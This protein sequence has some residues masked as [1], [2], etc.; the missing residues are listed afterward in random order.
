MIMIYLS[1]PF[2][3]FRLGILFLKN[4]LKKNYIPRGLFDVI[5]IVNRYRG[6]IIARS[7]FG[8]ILFD[9][10]IS[11]KI[12]DCIIKYEE[13]KKYYFNGTIITIYIPENQFGIETKL[14]KPQYLF[15]ATKKKSF[16]LNILSIQKEAIKTISQRHGKNGII[17]NLYNYTLDKISHF[18]DSLQNQKCCVFIDF[19]GFFS[20]S[21]LTKKLLFFLSSDYRINEQTNAVI[22]NLQDRDLILQVQLEILQSPEEDLNYIYHPIPCII[23]NSN[24]LEVLWLG[25]KNEISSENF[26]LVLK[27][28]IHDRS[29]S[30]FENINEISNTG[31]FHV[32]EYGNLIT[33]IGTLRD[34]SLEQ[35]LNKATLNENNRIYLC[36]GNYYQFEYLAIL[37]HL[38]DFDYAEYIVKMLYED[39]LEQDK[40]FFSDVTHIMSITLSSQLISNALYKIDQIN[41]KK[42]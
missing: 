32:D 11:S 7:N 20:D 16:Y 6:L 1:F 9:F 42:K 12:S 39:V 10:S 34:Q 28:E 31:M 19:D 35:L 4:I 41:S 36:S 38:Y 25:V 18:L 13:D 30:D 29:V 3:T 33:L 5:S 15:E 26:N 23:R 24:D 40:D 21:K 27:S 17:S 14:I 37:E 22:T 2:L 8:K